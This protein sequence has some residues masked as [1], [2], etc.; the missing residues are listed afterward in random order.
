MSKNHDKNAN[1][2]QYCFKTVHF[3]RIEYPTCIT[4]ITLTAFRD[5][6]R[7][8][9]IMN[10]RNTPVNLDKSTCTRKRTM[11]RF[12]S[13]AL[14]IFATNVAFSMLDILP[15]VSISLLKRSSLQN[16]HTYKQFCSEAR[17]HWLGPVNYDPMIIYN[18]SLFPLLFLQYAKPSA[19]EQK[20]KNCGIH[21]AF[22]NVLHRMLF[23][24]AKCLQSQCT[25]KVIPWVFV[26]FVSLLLYKA[27]ICE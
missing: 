26:C 1:I 15:N 5:T 19:L 16:N 3:F 11:Y 24:H 18:F 20:G 21:F 9:R 12:I 13:M 27:L 6:G 17:R 25:H 10:T 14:I 2:F 7:N 4:Y 8:D 23:L 22:I